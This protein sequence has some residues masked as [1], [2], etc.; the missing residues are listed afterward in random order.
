MAGRQRTVGGQAVLGC[1]ALAIGFV[2][3][4]GILTVYLLVFL[5][6]VVPWKSGV[7][8]LFWYYVLAVVIHL[9]FYNM[10]SQIDGFLLSLLLWVAF[11]LGWAIILLL[12]GVLPREDLQRLARLV[13][14]GGRK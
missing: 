12:G 4:E 14:P 1:G 2:V 13:R 9:N 8:P 6:R 7:A 3:A 10:S 11:T 5:S